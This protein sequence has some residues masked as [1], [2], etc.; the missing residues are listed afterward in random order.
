MENDEAPGVVNISAELIK[1]VESLI[2]TILLK[3]FRKIWISKNMPEDSSKTGLIVKLVRNGDLS[4]CI[5]L[6]GKTVLSLTSN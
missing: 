4:D 3:I 2:P 1:A 5:N 6:M